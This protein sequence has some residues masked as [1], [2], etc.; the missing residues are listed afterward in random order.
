MDMAMVSDD[1]QRKKN[2]RTK[3]LVLL[4]AL[5]GFVALIYVVSLVRLG[6]QG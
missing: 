4:A 2:L 3:N 5:L 6:G 1:E